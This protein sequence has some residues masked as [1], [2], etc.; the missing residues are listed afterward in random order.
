MS[1]KLLLFFTIIF[2][3]LLKIRFIFDL[4]RTGINHLK[5]YYNNLKNY[6]SFSKSYINSQSN[7]INFNKRFISRNNSRILITY[8]YKESDYAKENLNFFIKNGLFYSEKIQI[9]IIVKGNKCSANLPTLKNLKI[10]KTVNLGRDFSGYADSINKVD[11]NNF[12]YFIFLNDTVRGPFLPRYLDKKIWP[13]LFIS[14]LSNKTKLV[15]STINYWHD[16]KNNEDTKHIQSMSFATD[17][18]GIKLIIDNNIFNKKLHEK[19]LKES[20][21]SYIGKFEVG[22]SN[23]FLKNGFNIDC[24]QQSLNSKILKEHGDIYIDLYFGELINPLE[25]MF[26]KTNKFSSKILNNYTLWNKD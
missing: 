19:Y 4:S 16:G 25:I 24:L 13:F 2:F 26:I 21:Q 15:G 5:S 17:K 20:I 1:Y 23:I 22:L 8:V 11:V 12:D 9:N 18:I 10:Y 3:L 6:N 14:L 7:L